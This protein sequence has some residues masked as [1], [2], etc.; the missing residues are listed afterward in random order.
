MIT[1][2]GQDRH[3]GIVSRPC[4][5]E[6]PCC[7]GDRIRPSEVLDVQPAFFQY[8]APRKR[9]ETAHT[10]RVGI[11]CSALLGD[12]SEITLPMP[13]DD[14]L[15]AAIGDK[16]FG[17]KTSEDVDTI[18]QVDHDVCHDLDQDRRLRSHFGSSDWF[19]R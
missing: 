18:S 17:D 1:L 15:M 7:Q 12:P 2:S 10:D 13:N 14:T 19:D 3:D 11:L 8:V 16:T 6:K 9:F 5:P 4:G